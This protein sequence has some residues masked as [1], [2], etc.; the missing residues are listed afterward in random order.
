MGRGGPRFCAR[1]L[2][3][4]TLNE[5]KP[6]RVCRCCGAGSKFAQPRSAG[7]ALALPEER[8]VAPAIKSN[9]K[10]TRAMDLC[11]VESLL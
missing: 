10:H 4:Q 3:R 7:E 11:Y 1:G 9:V 5:E 8:V 2:C 6:R